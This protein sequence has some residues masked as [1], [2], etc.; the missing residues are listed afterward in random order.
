MKTIDYDALA[1]S[2]P[3][4]AD[5][6]Q[7]YGMTGEHDLGYTIPDHVRHWDAPPRILPVPSD[8]TDRTGRKFGR[9]TVIGY[10][11]HHKKKGSRWLVKCLCGLYEMRGRKAVDNPENEG[12]GCLR[13]R[14]ID[15]AKRSYERHRF[16][17]LYGYWPEQAQEKR[18]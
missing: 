4:N 3:L 16:K 6:A 11:G 5:A 10:L 14:R 13:C 7:A 8:T 12:D 17:D 15:H 1:A 9:F 18:P 2:A